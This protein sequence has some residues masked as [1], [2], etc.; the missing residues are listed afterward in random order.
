[1]KKRSFFEVFIS[2]AVPCELIF[3]AYFVLFEH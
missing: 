1:M 2:Q 3:Y